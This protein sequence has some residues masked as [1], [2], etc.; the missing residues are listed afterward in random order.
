MFLCSNSNSNLISGFAENASL[1]NGVFQ[2]VMQE[3]P[4][5]KENQCQ[6]AIALLSYSNCDE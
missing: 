5:C 1:S 4:L 2:Q 3:Y 6:A